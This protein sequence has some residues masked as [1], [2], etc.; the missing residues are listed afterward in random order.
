MKKK[1]WSVLALLVFVAWA[2]AAAAEEVVIG[3]SGPL[4]G[5]AAE[6]AQ[7]NVNGIDLAIREI[8][9]AGGILLK[10]KKY[11]FR[12]HKLDDRAGM[13]EAV[14]NARKFLKQDKTP[15]I[16]NSSATT[17]GALLKINEIPGSE[18]LVVGYSSVHTFHTPGSKLLI[19]PTPDYLSYM[20]MAADVAWKQGYRNGA[21]VVTLGAYGDAW[22]KN[23]RLVWEKKGGRILADCPINYYTETD[24]TAQLISAL[25]TRPDFLLIGGPSATTALAVEQARSMGFKG[26]FVLIDQARMDYIAGVLKN[27]TLMEGTIG[28]ANIADLPLPATPDFARKYRELYKKEATWES[29]LNYI[30]MHI[31]AQAM[32]LAGTGSDPYAIRAAVGKALPV[33]GDRYPSELF[34]IDE[35]GV[36]SSPGVIQSVANGKFSPVY[37]TLSFPKTRA[38][39]LKYKKMSKTKD[40]ENCLWMPL[41]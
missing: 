11:T 13:A 4:S 33:L 12:L 7:D 2:S 41:P 37:Y 3:Y 25:V 5:P 18:F 27:M 39:F 40:P 19:N 14:A 9:D 15:V 30:T 22:R 38:E 21:M 35:N 24:F 26:G 17:I 29:A 20:E 10:G 8:N 6:Y 36:I 34:R 28:I 23:F 31:I 16:F 32:T 1:M